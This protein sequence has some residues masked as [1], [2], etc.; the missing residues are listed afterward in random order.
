MIWLVRDLEDH[1]APE[2]GTS[3]L[4]QVTQSLIQLGLEH[5]E[6]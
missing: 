1:S 2:A 5:F 3:P 6:G 4:G